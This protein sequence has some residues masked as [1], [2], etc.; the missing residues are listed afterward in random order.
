MSQ[1]ALPL[2]LADHAVFSSFVSHGNEML[3]A[4]LEDLAA[5]SSQPGCWIAGPAAAGKTHLLQAL[6]DRAGDISVY[7]PL[8][9]VSGQGPDIIEAMASR[10]ILCLDDFDEVAGHPDWEQALFRLC[11]EVTTNDG[12]LVVAAKGPPRDSGIRLADLQ[13]RVSRLPVFQIQPLA[14]G[15]RERALQLRARHRGLELPDETARYLLTHARRDM[16][17]LYD[18]LDRLDAEA[19]R[20]QR[21]LTVPFVRTILDGVETN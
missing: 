9:S 17:S 19:L 10:N 14:D 18:V 15:D 16:A 21:R 11:N 4:F 13:S 12:K 20:A 2:K 6:C 1:L 3:V 5:L 7:V 8:A